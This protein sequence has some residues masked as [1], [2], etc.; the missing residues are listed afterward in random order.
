MTFLQDL[1]PAPVDLV[2]LATLNRRER[3]LIACTPELRR[4]ISAG[5]SAEWL[6]ILQR[7]Q[8][9]RHPITAIHNP[10]KSQAQGYRAQ[11]LSDLGEATAEFSALDD[12]RRNGLFTISCRVAKYV[13]HQYVSEVEFRSAFVAAVRTNGALVKYGI[14]WAMKTLSNALLC[15]SHDNLPPLARAFRREEVRS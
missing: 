9:T 11:A 10:C 13:H 3:A 7:W 12:G 8:T 6:A 5:T 1:L 14:V 4:E 15:A 2:Y